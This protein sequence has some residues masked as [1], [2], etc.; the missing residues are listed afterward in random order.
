MPEEFSIGTY[1]VGL[2]V[3]SDL[4]LGS[5]SVG[6]QL[7]LVVKQLLSRLG[8]ILNVG[9]LQSEKMVNMYL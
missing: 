6:Q 2:Q 8:S 1:V 5:V 4:S 3:G 9:S 7:L